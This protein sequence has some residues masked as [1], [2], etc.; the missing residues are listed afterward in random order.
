MNRKVEWYTFECRA[1]R[2]R[3]KQR[4]YFDEYLLLFGL[5]LALLLL[6]LVPP[7]PDVTT[8]GSTPLLHW[9]I[10][11]SLW[12]SPCPPPSQPC[13]SQTQTSESRNPKL[14]LWIPNPQTKSLNPQTLCTKYLLLFGLLLS[15]LLLNLV[16]R[17]TLVRLNGRQHVLPLL[18][19]LGQVHIQPRRHLQQ[20]PRKHFTLLIQTLHSSDTS[21]QTLHSSDT[22]T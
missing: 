12:P 11:S 22:K 17:L 2:G 18:Q 7:K 19:G 1:N 20:H 9:W 3:W 10:P 6:K 13:N 5:L 15:L 14:K 21:T 8:F 4:I 16:S